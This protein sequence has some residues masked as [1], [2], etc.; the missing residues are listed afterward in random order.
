M[1]P[2]PFAPLLVIAGAGSGGTNTLAH[3]VTHLN[4]WMIQMAIFEEKKL[5]VEEFFE[6]ISDS[7]E[8]YELVEGVARAMV[9]AKEGS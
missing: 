6:A 8:R 3:R 9:R 7:G 1:G 2:G 5:T 4:F